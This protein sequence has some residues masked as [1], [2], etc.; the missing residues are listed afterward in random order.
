MVRLMKGDVAALLSLARAC[1]FPGTPREFISVGGG[2][3]PLPASSSSL[4]K[5][6][7][8]EGVDDGASTMSDVKRTAMDLVDG[9][10]ARALGL[11]QRWLNNRWED[12]TTTAAFDQ[13]L[14]ADL[15][16]ARANASSPPYNSDLT[17][18][19]AAKSDGSKSENNDKDGYYHI[20]KDAAMTEHGDVADAVRAPRSGTSSAARE[21]LRTAVIFRL[22]QKEIVRENL[23][24][25]RALVK[26]SGQAKA[27]RAAEAK[28]VAADK[29]EAKRV[30]LARRNADAAAEAKPIAD[31][32]TMAETTSEVD[33]VA[34]A[35]ARLTRRKQRKQRHGDE[36][37]S[38]L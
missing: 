20:G 26:K 3:S 7:P 19:A 9:A 29:A 18:A 33:V 24:T 2:R 27:K 32:T 4:S 35:E 37:Y 1:A 5:L 12:F 8:S 10:E 31:G 21:R 25:V 22:Q 6:M 28:R 36:P 15:T 11:A 34:E 13:S 38:E 30:A 23:A 16:A 17:A 14:L